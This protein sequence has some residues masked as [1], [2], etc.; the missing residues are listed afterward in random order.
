MVAGRQASHFPQRLGLHP[1]VLGDFADAAELALHGG[2]AADGLGRIFAQAV[3]GA[4]HAARRSDWGGLLRTL[5]RTQGG[6]H[7]QRTLGRA[8]L[9]RLQ[10]EL[11][12]GGGRQPRGS[13][14]VV[15]GDVDGR[16]RGGG[17][18]VGWGGVAVD[19]DLVGGRG[20]GQDVSSHLGGWER[21][22]LRQ[23]KS[24]EQRILEPKRKR[25]EETGKGHTTPSRATTETAVELKLEVWGCGGCNGCRSRRW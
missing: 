5:R 2:P 11:V 14:R 8:Q 12:Q 23:G 13:G 9:P 7:V 22:E 18:G 20:R 3:E 19:G 17:G 16:G 21:R 25:G 10:R 15:G 6:G 4:V 24:Q 1:L